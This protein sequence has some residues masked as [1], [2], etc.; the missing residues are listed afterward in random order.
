M[1]SVISP[2]GFGGS[3]L[4]PDGEMQDKVPISYL[5]AHE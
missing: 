5:L 2:L 4:F 1:P 3:I